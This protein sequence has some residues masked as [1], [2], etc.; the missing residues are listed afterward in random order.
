VEYNKQFWRRRRGAGQ[1]V[2]DAGP[3]SGAGNG[4]GVDHGMCGQAVALCLTRVA[5][6]AFVDKLFGKAECRWGWRAWGELSGTA[7]GR[8]LTQ[9][10]L[11]RFACLF[12]VEIVEN[13][14]RRIQLPPV[15]REEDKPS[16]CM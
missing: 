8:A 9:V 11:Q 1:P 3:V 16:L 4:D 2:P 6:L 15:N 14:Q 12:C 5:A 7:I 13:S 10:K